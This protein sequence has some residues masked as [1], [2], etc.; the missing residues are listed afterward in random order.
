MPLMVRL[1][2]ARPAEDA[3]KL[4]WC[5][6]D[7]RC[8]RGEISVPDPLQADFCA[9]QQATG[10]DS[11]RDPQEPLQRPRVPTTPKSN[12]DCGGQDPKYPNP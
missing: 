1:Q 7:Q 6:P 4:R 12:R 2:N 11:Q 5:A 10:G 3:A 9:P 8:G